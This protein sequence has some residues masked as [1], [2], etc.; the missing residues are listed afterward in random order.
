MLFIR[1]PSLAIIQEFL[2]A[3]SK[4]EFS[5]GNVG[6]TAKV[7][8]T[9]YKVNHTRIKLGQG[10]EVFERAKTAL[11]GWEQFRIGW[12]ETFPMDTPIEVGAVVVVVAT[13]VGLWWL[14]ACRI[15]YVVDDAG[16]INQFGFAYGTLPDHCGMGEERFLVEWDRAS[17]DVFYDILAFSKPNQFLTRLGYPYMRRVQKRFGSASAAAMLRAVGAPEATLPL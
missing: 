6:A 14:N 8:P 11:R 12:V 3:Q 7:L 15:V 4:Q 9:H 1:K 5:Y 16:V 13:Q 2:K 17:D 10:A